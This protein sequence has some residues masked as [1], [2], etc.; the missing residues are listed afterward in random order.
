MYHTN[1]LGLIVGYIGTFWLLGF[2]VATMF[3]QP[4]KYL[5]WSGKTLATVW[6]HGW[7]FIVG[8]LI[9]AVLASNQVKP[10]F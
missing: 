9:G 2:A 4:K 10:P 5:D 7:K 1:S 3:K 6:K 8:I